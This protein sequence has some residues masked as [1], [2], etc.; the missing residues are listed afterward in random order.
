M[1]TGQILAG[2]PPIVAV[3]YQILIMFLIAAGT[4]FGT[5]AAVLLGAHRLFDGRH[6]L[7]LDR[8][9]QQQLVPKIG[10]D[11]SRQDAK[12]PRPTTTTLT[13]Y[14]IPRPHLH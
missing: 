12:A 11:L 2:S 1:M 14:A 4:G 9:Q 6:R 8:L 7:R 10:L 13:R 3:Q 5:I